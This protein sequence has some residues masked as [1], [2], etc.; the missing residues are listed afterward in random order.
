[1]SAYLFAFERYQI[2]KRG[3]SLSKTY[4]DKNAIKIEKEWQEGVLVLSV[5]YKTP[6]Q[7]SS[8]PL[9]AASSS[10]SADPRLRLIAHVF[11]TW[12]P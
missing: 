11:P 12:S 1:M 5:A 10:V 2:T 8:P 6:N 7:L 3:Q 9:S 4:K